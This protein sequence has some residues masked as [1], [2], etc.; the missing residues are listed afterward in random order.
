MRFKATWYAAAGVA[1]CGATSLMGPHALAICVRR[2][3]NMV[4][5][6][7]TC[8]RYSRVTPRSRKRSSRPL[9]A[10]AAWLRA[11]SLSGSGYEQVDVGR[12][13][14]GVVQEWHCELP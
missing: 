12:E 8:A 7:T 6:V 2:W 13:R 10:R 1:Y 11:P 14:I 9:R 4:A 5:R 3:S